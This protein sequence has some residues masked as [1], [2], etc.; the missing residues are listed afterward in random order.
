MPRNC[1]DD[2]DDYRDQE[3]DDRDAVHAVHEEDIHVAR[4]AWI[5]LFQEEVLLDLVPDAGTRGRLMFGLLLHT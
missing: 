4:L 2:Q 1:P 5:P 3:D